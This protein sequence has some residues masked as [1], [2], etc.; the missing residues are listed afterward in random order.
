MKDNPIKFSQHAI[1][2]AFQRWINRKDIKRVIK[3]PKEVKYDSNN[4]KF[5]CFGLATDSY[6]KEKKYLIVVF[7]KFNTYNL[8]ITAMGEHKEI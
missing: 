1:D 2:R 3:E 5:T 8:V 6:T 7:R 4:N